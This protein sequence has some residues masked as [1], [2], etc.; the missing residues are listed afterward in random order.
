M[1]LLMFQQA[2]DRGEHS[3]GVVPA[4]GAWQLGV[5]EGGRVLDVAAAAARAGIPAPTTLEA[6]WSQS[7]GLAR[8]R[9]LAETAAVWEDVWL[10]EHAVRFGPCV[11]APGK[12]LCVG[13]NYRRHAAESNM[14]VPETPVLFPKYANALAAHGETIY[15]PLSAQKLDY[16]AE[17]CI[18]IGRRAKHLSRE[19]ALYAVFGYCNANDLS[20]RDLQFRTSQW[21][22]GKT[23]DGFCPI[24]PYLVTADEVPDPNA[25]S[26]RCFVNGELRQDSNTADMVFSCAELVHY[27]SQYMTLEPGDLILTGTPEGVILGYPPERQRWLDAG[28]EVT[29][30][31]EGLGRLTNRLAREQI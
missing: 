8:L 12:I 30:E 21:L 24:G 9:A 26:I 15:A 22:L 19:E 13:L 25:L 1:K 14:P 7:D 27:V 5:A 20:A 10:A 31:I 11:P 28:D 2:V 17:L 4:R 23:C 18:V 29:V 6:V 16:E 3:A